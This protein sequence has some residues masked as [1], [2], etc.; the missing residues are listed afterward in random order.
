MQ[1]LTLLTYVHIHKPRRVF[2]PRLPSCFAACCWAVMFPSRGGCS[3]VQGE[4]NSCCRFL[5]QRLHNCIY[6][7][8][9][10]SIRARYN[11]GP[12]LQHKLHPAKNDCAVATLARPRD[13]I[14]TSSGRMTYPR[15]HRAQLLQD[16]TE[17]PQNRLKTALWYFCTHR[18]AK[19]EGKPD[20]ELPAART[21]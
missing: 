16:W 13:L 7:A 6:R 10:N 18:E 9:L 21:K 11:T 8:R 3:S 15:P 12:S 14:Q 5:L 20:Q 1:T 19:D 17:T 2:R 4:A